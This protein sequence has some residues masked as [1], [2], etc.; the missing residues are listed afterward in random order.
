MRDRNVYW[1]VAVQWIA[2]FADEWL[3]GLP[4]WCTRYFEP[5]PDPFWLRTMTVLTALMVA[6][7]WAASRPSAGSRVRLICAG[8]QML[9]F[10]NAC[11]HLITTI[12]FGAY[13]P[14]TATSVFLSVPLSVVVWR[15]VRREPDVTACSFAIALAA[16]FLFHALVLLN[17]LVDKSAW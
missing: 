3:F 6:L 13:S 2:H 7:A 10:S 16:G 15:T 1:L 9:F 5:L 8:V 11:F 4:A 17:L 14:G 12:V